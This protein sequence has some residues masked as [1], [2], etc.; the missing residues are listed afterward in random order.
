ME[1]GYHTIYVKAWDIYNNSSEE[2]ISF[3][4]E[5]KSDLVINKLFCF[6][7]PMQDYTSFQYSHNLPGNHDVTLSIYDMTGRQIYTVSRTNNEQGFVS[8]PLYWERKTSADELVS[9]GVYA[10]TIRVKASTEYSSDIF[11]SSQNGRLII[12]P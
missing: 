2:S 5:S 6:P 1:E 10:Y 9:P 12:I 8:E 7:N 4:V 11:E 3:Y